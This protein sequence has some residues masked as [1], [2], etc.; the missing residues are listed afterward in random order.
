MKSICS[1]G[2]LAR[3]LTRAGV[4]ERAAPL[5]ASLC[6]AGGLALLSQAAAFGQ[7]EEPVQLERTVLRE[8][9]DAATYRVALSGA[10]TRIEAPIIETPRSVSVVTEELLDEQGASTARDV[11]RNV[12]GLNNFAFNNDVTL[13]GFR[14]SSPILYNGLRGHA[15]N[16]FHVNPKLTNVERV[17]VLKGPASVLYSSLP[18]GGMINYVTRRP[19]AERINRVELTVGSYDLFNIHATHTGSIGGGEA[20]SYS[21]DV[22]FEDAG[23]FRDSQETDFINFA[24]AVAWRPNGR[25][26]LT[27]EVG[28]FDEDLGGHRDRGIPFFEGD[29]TPVPLSFSSQEETDFW[30]TESYYGELR[31]RLDLGEALEFQANARY[32]DA[33]V[34]EEYHEPRGVERDADDLD[35]D[36]RTDDLVM[37]R[38]F[39]V[40]DREN[41][42]F[43]ANAF[44]TWRAEWE[45]GRNAL[46]AG[47]D[48]WDDKDDNPLWKNADSVKFGGNVPVLDINSPRRTPGD[49]TRFDF[50]AGFA[51]TNDLRRFG[52]FAQDFVA[53]LDE[54]LHLNVGLRLDFFDDE[55]TDWYLAGGEPG[56][57]I[58]FNDEELLVQGGALYEVLE[59]RLS[60]YASYS[61]G[62]EPQSVTNQRPGGGGPFDPEISW[63]V[64]AGAKADIVPDHL[65]ATVALY[66]ITKENVLVGDPEDPDL[67][68]PLGEVESEG[69]EFEL[70]GRLTDRWHV[71][72][73]YGY[74][75][76]VVTED[77]NPELVGQTFPNAPSHMAGLWTGYEFVPDRL[78]VSGGF[79]FVDSRETFSEGDVIPS[80]TQWDLAADYRVSENFRLRANLRNLFDEEVLLGG[81][82]GRNGSLPGAPRNVSITATYEF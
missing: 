60:L 18:P 33:T 40:A 64:E 13:R 21:I 9:R 67:V 45:G 58:E 51:R 11:Y 39:R 7:G 31:Y 1:C 19:S 47:L 2:S 50:N 4:V 27:L 28:A 32:Y 74:N 42:G 3:R 82:G 17:E 5:G 23:S 53:L 22:E 10:A 30:E 35:G 77:S 16:I 75:D 59:D 49:N 44:A 46:N 71:T 12:A 63:Q 78:A 73:N 24:G 26:S 43:S 41:S 29:P 25:S 72:A 8:S 15:F 69:V 57:P 79:T 62:F 65:T 38:N 36:G 81:F 20:L 56:D 14:V 55:L 70:F 68:I 54:R 52:L 76:I 80:Y 61:E 66:T 34:R 48:F 6:L 37:I